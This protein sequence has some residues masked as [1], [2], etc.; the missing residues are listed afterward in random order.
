M[1]PSF[2]IRQTLSH[3]FTLLSVDDADMFADLSRVSHERDALTDDDHKALD[4][5]ILTVFNANRDL[6]VFNH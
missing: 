2:E 4:V 6:A 5:T 3:D 1:K